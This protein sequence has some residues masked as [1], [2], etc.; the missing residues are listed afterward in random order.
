VTANNLGVLFC[1]ARNR[2]RECLESHAIGG[3]DDA[4]LS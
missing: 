4:L 3:S 2:M 1:R